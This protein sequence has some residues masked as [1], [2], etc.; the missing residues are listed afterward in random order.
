MVASC[1]HGEKLKEKRKLIKILDHILKS[2]YRR[3]EEGGG[4]HITLPLIFKVITSVNM[5]L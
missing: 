3:N 1:V 2:V 5:K 4:S